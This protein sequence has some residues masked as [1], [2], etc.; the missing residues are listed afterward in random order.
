MSRFSGSTNLA[1]KESST[2]SNLVMRLLFYHCHSQC[3]AH[4]HRIVKNA[5]ATKRWKFQQMPRIKVVWNVE[6][7]INA[8][9]CFLYVCKD[10]N[11]IHVCVAYVWVMDSFSSARCVWWHVCGSETHTYIL[12]V[13]SSLFHVSLNVVAASVVCIKLLL[14][15][16]RVWEWMGRRVCLLCFVNTYQNTYEREEK[17]KCFFR[18]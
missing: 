6:K 17:K 16:F 12:A 15:W 10:L 9:F 7:S 1:Y 5:N 3:M 18:D 14:F 4:T 2:V 8:T 11:E 13:C